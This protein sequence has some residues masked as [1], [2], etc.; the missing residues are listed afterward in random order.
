MVEE[1]HKMCITDLLTE[2]VIS[3]YQDLNFSLSLDASLCL[4]GSTVGMARRQPDAHQ[5][6]PTSSTMTMR[7]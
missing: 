3:T 4:L 5:E 1:K 7:L 2:M 6:P